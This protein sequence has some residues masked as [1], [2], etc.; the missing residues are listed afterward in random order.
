MMICQYMCPPQP[1]TT[2][3]PPAQC[4]E[5]CSQL[6][7]V[8][9]WRWLSSR[10][11]CPASS[12]WKTTTTGAVIVTH[13]RMYIYLLS[14]VLCYSNIVLCRTGCA[15]CLPDHIHVCVIYVVVYSWA[16]VTS[17]TVNVECVCCC[18]NDAIIDVLEW[19]STCVTWHTWSNGSSEGDFNFHICFTSLTLYLNAMAVLF[20]MLMFMLL[21]LAVI[22]F[23]D[24][25]S[26]ESCC[27]CF[28][29]LV[30]NFFSSPVSWVQLKWRVW[31]HSLFVV[32]MWCALFPIDHSPTDCLPGT[33]T[34]STTVGELVC[35]CVCVCVCGL[36]DGEELAEGTC[37]RVYMCFAFVV[38]K[39]L[40]W[41]RHFSAA[42]GLP[43]CHLFLHLCDRDENVVQSL[44]CLPTTCCG[45]LKTK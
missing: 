12:H 7:P 5:Y 3:N 17:L 27:L 36:L 22:L 10:G 32:L 44:C 11:W 2:P 24:K 8:C 15:P 28:S 20:E 26:V 37:S 41:S 42:R 13:S 19:E 6:L 9:V 45:P 21:F 31:C 34:K 39:H 43:A 29:R 18:T 23:Q 40:L 4:S 25:R 1:P 38:W 35:V 16:T 33:P 14:T 30:E